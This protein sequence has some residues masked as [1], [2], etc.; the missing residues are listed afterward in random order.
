MAE[1]AVSAFAPGVDFVNTARL[2]DVKERMKTTGAKISV[3][4]LD[5]MDSF[6]LPGAVPEP[7]DSQR[8]SITPLDEKARRADKGGLLTVDDDLDTATIT[9]ATEKS[10]A[11]DTIMEDVGTPR[12]SVQHRLC[13]LQSYLQLRRRLVQLCRWEQYHRRRFRHVVVGTSGIG[14]SKFATYFAMYLLSTDVEVFYERGSFAV[15]LHPTGHSQSY[16]ADSGEWKQLLRRHPG[17][18]AWYIFDSVDS[19]GKA[20][21]TCAMPTLLITSPQNTDT[22]RRWQEWMKHNRA[23]KTTM[24]LPS[25]NEIVDICSEYWCRGPEDRLSVLAKV[26]ECI[27][28]AGLNVRECVYAETR[29]IDD[30]RQEFTRAIHSLD[31]D[32]LE[33]LL[34]GNYHGNVSS[35]VVVDDVVRNE[36]GYVVDW[37]KTFRCP[38]SLYVAEFLVSRYDMVV[39]GSSWVQVRNSRL[40]I[41]NEIARGKLFEALVFGLF[42]EV[43]RRSAAA[44]QAF[45]L[46]FPAFDLTTPRQ[47]EVLECPLRQCFEFYDFDDS[48]LQNELRI[49]EAQG[50]GH[51]GLSNKSNLRSFDAL[52]LIKSGTND[53][54]LILMQI[55]LQRPHDH[56]FWFED[57]KKAQNLVAGIVARNANVR[58]TVWYVVPLDKFLALRSGSARHQIHW[59]DAEQNEGAIAHVQVKV[60]CIDTFDA[61]VDSIIENASGVGP[62]CFF[63]I[64]GYSLLTTPWRCNSGGLEQR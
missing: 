28:V 52:A 17:D 39:G 54:E 27:A 37:N 12:T 18:R 14:K 13:V 6:G 51:V 30:L 41:G 11:G 16:D 49:V 20:P 23:G 29:S 47:R 35:R 21:E 58:T 8:T 1:E 43:Q 53:F 46:A 45:L 62:E 3:R 57:V 55:S 24:P 9:S 40:W 15:H 33:R 4:A 56:P 34:A 10:R 61:L 36:D 59:K 7:F 50:S 2:V 60:V 19:R 63:N 38:A 5:E 44:S 48:A 22:I 64:R 26:R 25:E 31:R 32:I 42:K